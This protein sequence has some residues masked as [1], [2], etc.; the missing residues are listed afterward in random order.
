MSR[1]IIE[2]MVNKSGPMV[3]EAGWVDTYRLYQTTSNVQ[4]LLR[5]PKDFL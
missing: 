4:T 1:E 2:R 3:S 5:A